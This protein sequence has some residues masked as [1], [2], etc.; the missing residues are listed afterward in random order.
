MIFELLLIF[1]MIGLTI[2]GTS[3]FIVF[4]LLDYIENPFIVPWLIVSII[5]TFLITI[6]IWEGLV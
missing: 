2:I 1:A 3:Y 4:L 6:I 5:L